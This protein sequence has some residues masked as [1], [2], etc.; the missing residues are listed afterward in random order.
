M[1]LPT[2]SIGA[3]LSLPVDRD[4]FGVAFTH[5]G[6]NLASQRFFIGNTLRQTHVRQYRQLKLG[7]VEPAAMLG[8]VV[9]LTPA[10]GQ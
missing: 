10:S 7:N 9:K 3:A 8:G 1:C 4:G 2:S 5:I 6:L